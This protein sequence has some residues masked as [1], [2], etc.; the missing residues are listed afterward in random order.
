MLGDA[1]RGQ[2]SARVSCY[3]WQDK[4][5]DVW[6]DLATVLIEEGVARPVQPGQPQP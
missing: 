5:G 6:L 4:S 3:G 2:R 1:D